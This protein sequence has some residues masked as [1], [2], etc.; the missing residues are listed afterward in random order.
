MSNCN[1]S[2]TGTTATITV[3]LAAPGS[4]SESGKS[5]VIASTHGFTPV[6]GTEFALSLNLIKRVPKAPKK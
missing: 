5:I 6:E 1:V 4:A 3:D 2:V